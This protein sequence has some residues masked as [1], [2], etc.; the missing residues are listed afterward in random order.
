VK[1]SDITIGGNRRP[2]KAEAVEALKDSIRIIGL[3]QPV[4]VTSTNRLV[5]GAHRLEACKE[6]GM[7]EI[8]AT[9]I[10]D[11][12]KAELA[13]LDENLIRNELTA[14]ERGVQTARRKVL[15]LELYPETARG[16]AQA[17]AMNAKRKGHVADEMSA[18]S[19]FTE[20]TASKTNRHS[21]SVARDVRIGN[22]PQDTLDAVRG[23]EIEDNQSALYALS[24]MPMDELVA[25]T[26]NGTEALVA[27]ANDRKRKWGPKPKPKPKPVHKPIRSGKATQAKIK[28]LMSDGMVSEEIAEELG[29]NLQTVREAMRASKRSESAA[30][31][32]R[33]VIN[34]AVEFI[35]AWE[36]VIEIAP[37]STASAKQKREASAKLVELIAKTQEVNEAIR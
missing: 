8:D 12:A 7:D 14:L 29:L 20:D 5:S 19:T 4:V 17:N 28:A 26:A 1:I 30:D 24:Q 3:Q 6:L 37:W 32:L 31:P 9:V 13:E 35:D 18:T 36:T 33:G 15:Y 16:T 27:E 21:R 11:D 23:S 2:V 34:H 22:L 10:A 25:A